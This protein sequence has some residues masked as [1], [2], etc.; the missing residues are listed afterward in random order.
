MHRVIDEI[1]AVNREHSLGLRL[2]PPGER[3]AL[4][5]RVFSRYACR[6]RWMWESFSNYASVQ[7]PDGWARIG[8]L[9]GDRPCI[10]LFD[11]DE[12]VEMFHVP[13]GGALHT[14]LANSYG[15]EFYVTDAEAGY[16][17]CFNHHDM[18]ICC[19]SARAWLEGDERI[20]ND[21]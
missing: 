7:D 12:E 2:L 21:A 8:E 6:R 15:F 16:L 9:A 10:L 13:S 18:L 11:V 19:G 17:V 5:E 14:L 1:H 4:R 3:D 20:G